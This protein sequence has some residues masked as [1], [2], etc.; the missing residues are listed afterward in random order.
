MYY[1]VGNLW[2]QIYTLLVWNNNNKYFFCKGNGLR[3]M[4]W[5]NS[6][7]YICWVLLDY[8]QSQYKLIL[9]LYTPC[10]PHYT[11]Y[12]HGPLH[13]AQSDIWRCRMSQQHSIHLSDTLRHCQQCIHHTTDRSKSNNITVQSQMLFTYFTMHF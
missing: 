2:P 4:Y 12:G 9:S 13:L 8:K 6:Y 11:M 7:W 5:C 10:R 3:Y 1:T